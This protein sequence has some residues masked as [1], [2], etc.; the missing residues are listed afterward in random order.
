MLIRTVFT[1]YRFS[2]N[3]KRRV[4]KQPIEAL[5]S[6]PANNEIPTNVVPLRQEEYKAA[7]NCLWRVVQS[8]VYADEVQVLVKSY[9]LETSL[10]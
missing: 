1:V 6:A 4:Q 7:E 2:S 8:E 5:P 9:Q 3:C 10:V